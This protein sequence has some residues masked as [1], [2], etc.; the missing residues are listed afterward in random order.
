MTIF[1][2]EVFLLP[3]LLGYAIYR[4]LRSMMVR[5]MTAPEQ[6]ISQRND[7]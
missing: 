4:A 5:V 2:M 7:V 1:L 3:S 6:M